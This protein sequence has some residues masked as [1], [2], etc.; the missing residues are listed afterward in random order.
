MHKTISCLL[1][2]VSIVAMT[3]LVLCS[4]A[5]ANAITINSIAVSGNQ[6]TI[7]GV[8]FN[9]TVTVT[10]GGQKL[11]ISSSAPTQIVA[12][13]D[14]IP[15]PGSY[16]LVVKAGGASTSAYVAMPSAPAVVATIALYNQTAGIP[17]T[18]LYTPPTTGL[19]RF[20][21]YLATTAVCN[22]TGDWDVN[23]QWTAFGGIQSL[24]TAQGCA[25]IGEHITTAPGSVLEG[26]PIIYWVDANNVTSGDYALLLTVERSM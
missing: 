1:L 14:P 24:G 2:A 17:T 25:G 22:T 16:R 18:T 19:Y 21:I 10:L 15:A 7:G 26:Q 23:L 12:T 5:S 3:L 11:N 6:L 20:T 8:G 9:G 13:A 4:T